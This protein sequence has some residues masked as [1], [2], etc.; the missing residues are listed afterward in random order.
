M[1]IVPFV[2]ALVLVAPLTAARITDPLQDDPGEGADAGDSLE[3]ATFLEAAAAAGW[4]S[5]TVV[6]VDDPVDAYAV[7]L[8][9][10]GKPGTPDLRVVVDPDLP[11]DVALILLAPT[12]ETYVVDEHGP[13]RAETVGA[14]LGI[15]AAPGVWRFSVTA[16][17]ALKPDGVGAGG[18]LGLAGTTP[19]ELDYRMAV[20]CHPHC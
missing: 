16:V 12:G 17:D 11:F 2:L 6:P 4:M 13:G 10:D 19:L 7:V 15:E 1:R 9:L 18:P 3:Q 8:A 5:G 20:F 14:P